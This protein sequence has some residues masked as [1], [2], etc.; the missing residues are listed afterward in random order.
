MMKILALVVFCLMFASCGRMSQNI[1]GMESATV[2]L[3]RTVTQ[4]DFSGKVIQQFEG[5]FTVIDVIGG[6][7]FVC[8][9][10]RVRLLGGIITDIE[11]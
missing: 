5:R 3:D 6:V 10:K 9:G 4:Y 1:K 2:G 11:K 7:K 8:N